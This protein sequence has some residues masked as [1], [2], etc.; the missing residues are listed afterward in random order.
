MKQRRAKEKTNVKGPEK[1]SVKRSWFSKKEKIHVI[2]HKERLWSPFSIWFLY[3]F[4]FSLFQSKLVSKFKFLLKE[5]QHTFVICIS[6]RGSQWV[7]FSGLFSKILFS[8]SCAFEIVHVITGSL[9]FVP[10][11]SCCDVWI[12]AKSVPNRNSVNTNLEQK[13]IFFLSKLFCRFQIFSRYSSF[14]GYLET[15][16]NL[17]K[18]KYICSA[19]E[20]DWTPP[21]SVIW[22]SGSKQGRGEPFFQQQKNRHSGAK[23]WQFFLQ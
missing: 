18:R 10:R 22:P 2:R 7:I 1:K 3:N 21:P 13:E 23:A 9:V 14:L 4:S 16:Q 12:S 19:M 20:K 6:H 11:K 8:L 17:W 15:T 5:S